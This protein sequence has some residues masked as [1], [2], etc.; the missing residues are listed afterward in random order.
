M[1]TR[2]HLGWQVRFHQDRRDNLHASVDGPELL[3]QLIGKIRPGP[4]RR[5]ALGTLAG[6][7]ERQRR[8]L[9]QS[10]APVGIHRETGPLLSQEGLDKGF[11][12]SRFPVTETLKPGNLELRGLF[13]EK[14]I[15]VEYYAVDH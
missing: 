12:I 2:V 6:Q 3:L 4:S 9:E 14:W 13:A 7:R 10:L 1:A 5:G 11:Q 8:V 15:S